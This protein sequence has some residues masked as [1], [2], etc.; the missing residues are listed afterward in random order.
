MAD[1]SEV[2]AGTLKASRIADEALRTA[3]KAGAFKAAS[4]T[5]RTLDKAGIPKLMRVLDT[6]NKAGLFKIKVGDRHAARTHRRL[7]HP[8]E[9]REHR[10]QR[11]IARATSSTDP[12]N[13]DPDLPPS[14]GAGAA[15]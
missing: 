5:A 12:P 11:H 4:Q 2:I 3:D 7:A 14:H 13:E 9:R 10:R 6:A 8:R 1:L 15:W